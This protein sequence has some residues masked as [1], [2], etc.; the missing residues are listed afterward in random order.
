LSLSGG[1]SYHYGLSPTS[2][3][4]V[5]GTSHTLAQG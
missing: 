1:D 2:G 5:T 3:I 4:V